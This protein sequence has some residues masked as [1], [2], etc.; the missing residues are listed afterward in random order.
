MNTQDKSQIVL[1]RAVIDD[2]LGISAVFDAAVRQGWTYLSDLVRKPMFTLQ[3][4][5]QDIA[6]H[7]DPNLLLVAVN[8]SNEIV[9]FTAVHPKEGEMFLLF[10]HP[11]QAG[12]GIGR[13]L[14]T[15]ADAA[16]RAA[17]CREAFLFTH[18]QNGRALAVYRAAGYCSDGSVRESNFRGTVM[19][20]LRLVKRL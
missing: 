19:R 8:D 16:L 13:L 4:W 5:E 18:E 6:D 20:E 3:E 17:G 9:G 2:A 1:R 7:A 10:V 11:D 14:L 15:A 12:R